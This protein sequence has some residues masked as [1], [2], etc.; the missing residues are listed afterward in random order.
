MDVNMAQSTSSNA[1]TLDPTNSTA[2]CIKFLLDAGVSNESATKYAATFADQCI[3]SHEDLTKEIR[4]DMDVNRIGDR[5]NILKFASKPNI[6][7]GPLQPGEQQ[8][9]RIKPPTAS[10][11]P[12]KSEMTHPEFRKLRIDWQFSSRWT[13]SQE[14]NLPPKSTQVAIKISK[15]VL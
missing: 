11:P 5:I 2:S 6:T 10:A 7:G 3:T 8:T 4:I 13:D 15:R 1:V 9:P 12:I 14:P